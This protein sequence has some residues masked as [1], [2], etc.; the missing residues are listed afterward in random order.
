MTTALHASGCR[1]PQLPGGSFPLHQQEQFRHDV[2]LERGF[3][4][5]YGRLQSEVELGESAVDQLQLVE[6]VLADPL[7]ILPDLGTRNS[8]HPPIIASAVQPL[9]YRH[10]LVVSLR[11][12]SF[13]S[14]T[15]L[16]N[17]G[18]VTA[19]DLP[20]EILDQ[21]RRE[22]PSILTTAHVA[23]MMH[24]TIGDV[25]DKVHR[26]DLPA[27]RWGQQFRFFREEVLAAMTRYQPG[28]TTPAEE[29]PEPAEPE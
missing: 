6:S 13:P 10:S 23:E 3:L 8:S 4:D 28:D 5:D 26:G 1:L 20:Q 25:R 17:I 19:P 18:S 27:V 2:I 11:T 24:S 22:Y 14:T 21:L 15:A 12:G 9:E 7:R 16:R 29:R